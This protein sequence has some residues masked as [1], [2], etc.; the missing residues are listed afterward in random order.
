[1][2]VSWKKEKGGKDVAG[3]L[4]I[5]VMD[6]GTVVGHETLLPGHNEIDDDKWET[7]KK[8]TAI[9]KHIEAGNIQE[10]YEEV[11]EEAR[12]RRRGAAGDDKETKKIAKKVKK[13]TKMSPKKAREIVQDTWTLP[14]LEA[15]LDEEGRDEIRAVIQNQIQEIKNPTINPQGKRK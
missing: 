7:I 3:V 9:T 15:W 4:V 12:S 10:V 2:I 14:T 11:E 8:T 5:P 6:E 1:M 13:L